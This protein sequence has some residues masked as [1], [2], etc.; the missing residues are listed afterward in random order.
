MFLNSCLIK[1]CF[2]ESK[3]IN[4]KMKNCIAH[5]ISFEQSHIIGSSFEECEMYRIRLKNSLIMKTKF[6]P[7]IKKSMAGLN[8]SY[9]IDSLFIDCIFSEM[10]LYEVNFSNSSFINCDFS[11]ANLDNTNFQGSHIVKCNFKNASMN[12]IKGLDIYSEK[13]GV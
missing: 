13:C 11:F 8:K 4:M 7:G 6:V 10:N 3:L 1:A 2:N 9:F 5:G 12:S